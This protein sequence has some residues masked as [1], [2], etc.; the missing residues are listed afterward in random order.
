ML[1]PSL[2]LRAARLRQ[3]FGTLRASRLAQALAK[4][5]CAVERRTVLGM[6]STDQPTGMAPMLRLAYVVILIYIEVRV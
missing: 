6:P 5:L 1:E 4:G 3:F 2:A